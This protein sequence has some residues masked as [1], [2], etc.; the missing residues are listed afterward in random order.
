MILFDEQEDNQRCV[1]QNIGLLTIK[2][3]KIYNI[4]VLP[5]LIYN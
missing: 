1:T 3:R 2:I 4:L 5:P